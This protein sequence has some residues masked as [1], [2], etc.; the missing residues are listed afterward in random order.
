MTTEIQ[1]HK[2]IEPI[3][4]QKPAVN[5]AVQYMMVNFGVDEWATIR[6][7]M[8][9]ED[10]LAVAAHDVPMSQAES[11]AWEGDDMYVLKLA[12]DKLGISSEVAPMAMPRG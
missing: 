8:L 3:Q 4:T 9:D 10:G 11:E 12:L 6:V 5:A 1:L 2:P 7:L